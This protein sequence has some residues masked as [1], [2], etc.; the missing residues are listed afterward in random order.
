MKV[1]EMLSATINGLAVLSQPSDNRVHEA[2]RCKR[3]HK[4]SNGE[5]AHGTFGRLFVAV[6]RRRAGAQNSQLRKSYFRREEKK[7]RQSRTASS[8]LFGSSS[9]CSPRIARR[10]S[11]SVSRASASLTCRNNSAFSFLAFKSSG[12]L[13]R[14]FSSAIT[15]RMSSSEGWSGIWE[16]RNDSGF[17]TPQLLVPLVQYSPLSCASRLTAQNRPV[18]T[19]CSRW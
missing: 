18:Y 17:Y 5:E 7:E 1:C 16:T 6:S 2:Q 10:N 12:R 4:G 11:I 8:S 14:L 19:V 15:S 13:P 9:S 3:L